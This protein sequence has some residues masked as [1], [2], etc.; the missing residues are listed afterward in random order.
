MANKFYQ[1]TKYVDYIRNYYF[2]HKKK[3]IFKGSIK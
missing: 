2:A 1:K 3:N